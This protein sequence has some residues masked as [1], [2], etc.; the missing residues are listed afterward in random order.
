MRSASLRLSATVTLPL[1]PRHT[2]KPSLTRGFLVGL[3]MTCERRTAAMLGKRRETTRDVQGV[4]FLAPDAASPNKTGVILT[5]V[6][7]VT[8]EGSFFG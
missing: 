5:R 3:D 1:H 7:F 4:A 6:C 2:C 8:I